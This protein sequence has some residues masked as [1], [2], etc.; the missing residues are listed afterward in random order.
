MVWKSVKPLIS[1]ES[2]GRLAKAVS[3]T[4]DAGAVNAE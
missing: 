1:H 4:L 3:I 2:S